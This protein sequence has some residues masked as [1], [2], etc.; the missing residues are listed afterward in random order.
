MPTNLPEKVKAQWRKVASTK[1]PELKL[2][3]LIKFYSMIPKHKGT[4][5]LVKQVK[6]QIAKLRRELE[7]KRK[8][9]YKQFIDSWNQEKHG[10][11]RIAIVGYDYQ[12]IVN[13][14]CLL[15]GK[16]INNEIWKFEPIYGV[17]DHEGLQFQTV[18]LPPMGISENLNYKIINYCKKSDVIYII[19]D[20]EDISEITKQA[21]YYGLS[22]IKPRAY[23]EISKQ[24]S[25]GIR[26]IGAYSK[27]IK[28]ILNILREYNINNAIVRIEGEP[29][30]EDIE[31]SILGINLYR[32]TFIVIPK[33]NKSIII[34]RL[35]DKENQQLYSIPRDKDKLIKT[36][37]NELNLIRVYTRTRSKELAKK[38][39]I[40]KKG[41]NVLELAGI[42]HSDL[43]RNF[44]YAVLKRGFSKE[45]KVS[46]K[47]ILEDGDIIEIRT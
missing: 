11:A 28:D 32:P 42:I 14:F 10:V 41:S 31:A 5:N 15:T 34:Y 30:T 17:L 40:I 3:E 13:L 39:I 25:G 37:L 12:Q 8:V 26:V 6:R 18:L 47:Y 9:K 4:K 24:S 36:L 20:N 19:S 16:A 33:G 23:I 35:G 27:K 2:N 22:L 38:P 44:K 43:K 45:I 1:D 7:S 21:K 46:G 29:S